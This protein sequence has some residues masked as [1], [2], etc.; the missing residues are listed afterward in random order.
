MVSFHHDSQRLAVGS[1]DN[2]IVIYD[3][4]TASRWHVLEGHKQSISAVAFSDNGKVLASYSIN[5]STVRIWQTGTSFFGILGSRPP[6]VK[7]YTVS[8]P[9]SM[10]SLFSL[11]STFEVDYLLQGQLHHKLSYRQCGCSG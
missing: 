7:Q 1:P 10:N 11:S 6:C 9:P 4:K 8:K 5:D 3:L 2:V